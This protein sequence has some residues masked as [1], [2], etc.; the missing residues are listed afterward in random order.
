MGG[1]DAG[2]GRLV[3]VLRAV[4]RGLGG[5]VLEGVDHLG[6]VEVRELRV[7]NAARRLE[8]VLAVLGDDTPRRDL[9]LIGADLGEAAA[10]AEDE[11]D[12]EEVDGEDAEGG[13]VPL[14]AAV[15]HGGDG[16]GELGGLSGD[17]ADPRDAGDRDAREALGAL[18]GGAVECPG[19]GRGELG[20]EEEEPV[21][22][23]VEAVL[24]GVPGQVER[25]S[26]EDVE[27][28]EAPGQRERE[29]P[30]DAGRE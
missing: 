7:G 8:L 3:S 14:G 18:E 4:S 23:Q 16:E 24:A 12:L 28:E 26:G 29:D 15:E 11:G 27:R 22:G 21:D 25:E 30:A 10:L 13:G 9:V 2:L 19:E 17:E 5:G 1:R 6:L 20:V